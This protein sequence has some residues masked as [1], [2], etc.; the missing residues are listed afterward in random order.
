MGGLGLAGFL[1]GLSFVL[2]LVCL[3][4]GVVLLVYGVWRRDKVLLRVLAGLSMLLFLSCFPDFLLF[5]VGS[6]RGGREEVSFRR[7]AVLAVV[8]LIGFYLFVKVHPG[9]REVGFDGALSGLLEG[10]EVVPLMAMVG[11]KLGVFAWCLHVLLGCRRGDYVGV[12]VREYVVGEGGCLGERRVWLG[13]PVVFGGRFNPHELYVGGSGAGK[14][15]AVKLRVGQ[16]AGDASR[17]IIVFDW[18]GEYLY[19]EGE[20]FRVVDLAEGCFNIFACHVGDLVDAASLAFPGM[21]DVQRALL[22]EH[23]S[24]ACSLEELGWELERRFVREPVF[25][26]KGAL[27]AL[28]QRLKVVMGEVKGF[29]LDPE[30]LLYGRWVVSFSGLGVEE[31]KV[32]LAELLL[33]MLFREALRLAPLRLTLVVDEAHRLLG[34]GD[35]GQRRVEPFINRVMREVR[36]YGVQVVAASQRLS[37][38]PD[39]CLANF[40]RL[41]VMGN[42]SPVDLDRLGGLGWHLKLVAERLG[43][44]EGFDLR[45]PGLAERVVVFR[46]NLHRALREGLPAARGGRRGYTS[47]R[48]GVA[49]EEFTAELSVDDRRLLERLRS[50]EVLLKALRAAM[51]GRRVKGFAELRRLG[52]AKEVAGSVRLTRQGE[53][54]VKALGLKG[55][56]EA[57]RRV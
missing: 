46:F 39:S 9:F 56:V 2:G 50:D 41:I 12:V 11:V 33:R 42:L 51:E 19:L 28:W 21:G 17:S 10:L 26:V 44:G 37:D 13:R 40:G 25:N 43:V 45:E 23:A 8:L 22:Y 36:K 57:G 1:R 4:L 14:S 3:A 7:V 6:V 48:V 18:S 24:S 54:L 53:R 16:L 5:V 38:L 29:G 49:E 55:G 32:F 30:R 52:L 27:M 34:H 47:C 15:N 31:C 20:G 35:I